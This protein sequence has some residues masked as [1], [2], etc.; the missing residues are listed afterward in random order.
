MDADL[1]S[2]E[3][4]GTDED[5]GDL[6]SGEQVR[7]D[8]DHGDLVSGEQGE[9]TEVVHVSDPQPPVEV[10]HAGEGAQVQVRAG[11]SSAG[12]VSTNGKTTVPGDSMVGLEKGKLGFFWV[13]A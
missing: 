2:C 4:V 3:Q 13:T 1:V 8:E 12:S 6:V 7:V 9:L 5:H 10:V 11:E